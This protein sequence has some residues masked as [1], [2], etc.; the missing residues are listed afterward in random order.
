[1]SNPLVL[2]EILSKAI[3]AEQRNGCTNAGVVGGFADFLLASIDKLTG[4]PQ[5]DLPRYRVILQRINDLAGGYLETPP[6]QRQKSLAEIEKLVGAL[7]QGLGTALPQF[8]LYTVQQGK[9]PPAVTTPDKPK[10]A[11]K[12]VNSNTPGQSTS[13]HVPLNLP[14]QYLKSVGPQ[15][16]KLLNRLG[17]VSVEDLLNHFPRR[18]EDRRNIKSIAQVVPGEVETVRGVV[19]S[20]QELSPRRGLKIFKIGLDD[21]TGTLQA[22][23]FNNPYVLK[24]LPRGVQILATGKVE[25]RF[26]PAEMTVSDF[27]LWE[28]G[29]AAPTIIPVYSSTDSLSSKQIRT[30]M[31]YAL[32]KVEQLMPEILSD[33]IRHKYHLPA[34]SEAYRQIHFPTDFEQRDAARRRLVFEEFVLLQLGIQ[35]VK[36]EH[37]SLPGIAMP[38]DNTLVNRLRINLPFKLTQA[39]ERVIAEIFADMATP[40]PMARLV[41]GD[42][43][44]GKTVVAAMALLKAVE[45]GYQG[46]MM[47]PTEILAEQ[48]FLYLQKVLEPLGVRVDLLTGSMPKKER[49]N[50]LRLAR[51]GVCDILVGTHALIQDTVGFKALGLAVTDEQHRFGVKQRAVLQEK[52][53]NPHVLVMTATPIP[54]TL[55]LTLYGDLNLSVIDELPPG[56]QE[57][58]TL[59]I[60]ENSR[61]RL[62]QFI[63]REISLQRQAY[64]VCPLVAE[65]EAVDLKA[66]TELA[67]VLAGRFPRYNVGLLHGKMKSQEKEAIMHKFRANEIQ[68]LVS[69]T[70]IEVGVDVP[71]ASLMVVE[72]AER[73]GLAQLHQLRGRVGRGEYKSYC[74]LVTSG[75]NEE[76][77]RRMGIMRQTNDGFKIAEADLDMRGPGEFFGTRQH[78]LPE[79]KIADILHDGAVLEQAR[80]TAE[81]LLAGPAL[82]GLMQEVEKRFGAEKLVR[83]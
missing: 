59:H 55:A 21:G 26:G 18:Y 24:Q 56:R 64:V 17:I 11:G 65:S 81:E 53:N 45:S 2:L 27:E 28:T 68:L 58:K 46:A 39:Q 60:T 29:D 66:A 61:E 33:N 36:G 34:R 25:R 1:M 69:T 42:V 78:G 51:E 73:F 57:I 7:R 19:L 70:V 83:G 52:G 10:P 15:R 32:Q 50:V 37:T 63:D 5:A 41:Q 38:G 9:L 13:A 82:P 80:L 6:R 35:R 23:W 77:R 75:I 54:R 79:L 12:A 47:A 71:N 44:S 8:S 31:D 43:G 3:K 67:D 72:G 4:H 14:V 20:H 16:A 76:I 22:V 30:L 40:H 49:E 62:Y 48:H 74:I